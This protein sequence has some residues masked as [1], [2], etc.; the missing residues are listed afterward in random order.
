[1]IENGLEEA[2]KSHSGI[3][4]NKSKPEK[5]RTVGSYKGTEQSG[6]ETAEAVEWTPKLGRG[7]L[8]E[9]GYRELQ[10]LSN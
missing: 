10:M 8:A 6:L 9:A 4:R 5:M 2:V 3:Q 7:C 1:M